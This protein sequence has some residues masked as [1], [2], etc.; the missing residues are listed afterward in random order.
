MLNNYHDRQQALE[1]TFVLA[2]DP[3]FDLA[4]R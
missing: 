2:S 3:L 1:P 4:V